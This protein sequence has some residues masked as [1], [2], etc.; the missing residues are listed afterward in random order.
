[1]NDYEQWFDEFESSNIERFKYFPDVSTLL[2]EFKG[3]AQ[4]EYA[5]V[6]VFTVQDMIQAP[7]K[8]K[9]LAEH[10]KGHFEYQKL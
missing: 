1:M 10:I 6:G 7:S 5:D 9:F 2:V 8:G 4:Y 3:G